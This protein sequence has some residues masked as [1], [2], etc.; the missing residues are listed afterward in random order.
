M[1]CGVIF[2]KKLGWN[3]KEK[4]VYKVVARKDGK[5]AVFHMPGC[6]PGQVLIV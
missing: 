2:E 5:E 6:S 1:L 4:T 3:F